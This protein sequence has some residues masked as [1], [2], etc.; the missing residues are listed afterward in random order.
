MKI[1]NAGYTGNDPVSC[2]AVFSRQSDGRVCITVSDSVGGLYRS[3]S[4]ENPGDRLTVYA[5]IE[6]KGADWDALDDGAQKIADLLESTLPPGD[7]PWLA[8]TGGEAVGHIA[9][10]AAALGVALDPTNL[11]P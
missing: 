1:R 7:D 11:N 10:A 2:W 3:L 4:N 5:S 9:A 6:T 8:I